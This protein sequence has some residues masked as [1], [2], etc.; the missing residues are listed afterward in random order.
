VQWPIDVAAPVDLGES[1]QARNPSEI[2]AKEQHD[3]GRDER[4]DRHEQAPRPAPDETAP[5]TG[6][7][8]RLARGLWRQIR[9]RWGLRIGRRR[10]RLTHN[11]SLPRTYWT[12]TSR[13]PASTDAPSATAT[14]LTEPAFGDASSFSIFIASMTTSGCL[15]ATSSPAL[16]STR[17]M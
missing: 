1:D 5:R 16:T 11:V 2:D 9:G 8:H 17:T 15:A 3:P 13:R 6:R 12:T 4:R 10:R 14:S 7:T